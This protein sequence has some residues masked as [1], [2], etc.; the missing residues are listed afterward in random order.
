MMI[1][2][3]VLT[4]IAGVSTFAIVESTANSFSVMGSAVYY[5]DNGGYHLLLWAYDAGGAPVAGVVAEFTAMTTGLGNGSTGP[6][7]ATSNAQGEL[8]LTVPAIDQAGVILM[9]DSVSLATH[10]AVTVSW[11]GIFWGN[12]LMLGYVPLGA[13]DGLNAFITVGTDYY[14]AHTQVMVFAAGPNGTAPTGLRLETCSFSA[15]PQSN[16]TGLSTKELGPITTYWTHSPLPMY[17]ANAT[18]VIVQLVNGSGGI[19]NEMFFSPT[20]TAG[21]GA[22]VV[23]QAPGAPIL[24]EFT[25]EVSFTLPLLA[26]IAPYWAY[27]QPRLSGTVEPVLARPVTRRGI[28]LARYASVAIALVAAV[29]AEALILIASVDGILGEPLPA[30]FAA[31]LVGGLVVAAL[32][33]AGLLFLSA[34]LVRSPGAALA[35]GITL[36]V[37]WFFWF[38]VL[39]GLLI[40]IH[41]SSSSLVATTLVTRS[42][43]LS[44]PQFPSLTTSLLTGLSPLGTPLG[45]AVGGVSSVVVAA[46]AVAWVVV[47]LVVAYSCAVMRD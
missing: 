47:P 21:S 16:C 24:R 37:V 14:S 44:P 42:Q 41:V 33:F 39:L 45:S 32:S 1:A 9:L 20:A 34:H 5:Y 29:A 7:S 2:I 17:P 35:I 11:G 25:S 46:A 40:L 28:F 13:V 4:A 8:S 27:A 31:P 6:Y 10:R 22:T 38:D 36:L 15:L 3:A 23:N 12:A 30:G 26:L 19:V 18:G 43:L